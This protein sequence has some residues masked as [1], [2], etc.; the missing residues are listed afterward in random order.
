[1][2]RKIGEIFEFGDEWYQ[3]VEDEGCG[4]CDLRNIICRR[5][6][7]V[8]P[9][10][11]CSSN[12]RRT[13]KKSVIFKKLKKTGKLFFDERFGLVQK[14]G[15]EMYSY[16]TKDKR[17]CFVDSYD[18]FIKIKQNKKDMGDNA[19]IRPYDELFSPCTVSN[20]KHLAKE[21]MEEKEPTYEELRHYYHSTVGLWAIDRS[22]QE[23]NLDWIC[24]NAFQLGM[25][26]T[27]PN[28][29][30]TEKN[31]KPFNLEAARS[32]K[33]VC[34]RDGRK[35]RIICFDSNGGRPIVA[36]VTECDDEEEMPYKY[37]CDGYYNC[38]SIPS[39]ND[40]MMLPERKEGWVNV[41]K[42]RIYSTKE[43]AVEATCDGVTYIDTIKFS[44]E[45]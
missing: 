3:C 5:D 24:K 41:Y 35:A 11:A 23:V 17:V 13:D 45:E 19:D 22:P 15:L 4:K 37:H 39:D 34:T 27:F 32:G 2:E 14:Y 30:R 25:D 21:D 16:S 9:F 7:S 44:W 31:L 42:E 40:L 33:P 18:V 36:L 26:N 29:E 10:K 6:T 43:E 1:M 20:T 28:C 8:F 38:Q 12:F